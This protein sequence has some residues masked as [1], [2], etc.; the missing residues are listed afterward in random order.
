MR[1]GRRWAAKGHLRPNAAAFLIRTSVE[2]PNLHA[3]SGR[4][5]K[6]Y[7]QLLI[8]QRTFTQARRIIH[9][10]KLTLFYL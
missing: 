5:D 4:I 6:P 9:T 10:S 2:L 8:V 1:V 7:K 3:F